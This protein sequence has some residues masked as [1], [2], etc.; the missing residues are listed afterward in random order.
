M[1]PH[2]HTHT[3]FFS[4]SVFSFSLFHHSCMKMCFKAGTPAQHAPNSTPT[5]TPTGTPCRHAHAVEVKKKWKKGNIKTSWKHRKAYFNL[6]KLGM[7]GFAASVAWPQKKTLTP[8]KG[9]RPPAPPPQKKDVLYNFLLIDVC[10]DDADAEPSSSVAI[11][12][13][14]RNRFERS[15]DVVVVVFNV[16]VVSTKKNPERIRLIRRS[17]NET[18]RSH[19]CNRN[20]SSENWLMYSAP[21]FPFARSPRSSPS[22][23]SR[24]WS[25]VFHHGLVKRLSSH[26]EIHIGNRKPRNRPGGGSGSPDIFYRK[27][28]LFVLECT[29]GFFFRWAIKSVPGISSMIIVSVIEDFSS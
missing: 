28:V 3:R 15:A 10:S 19:R 16:V 14:P 29:F 9:K 24:G 25:P 27:K 18:E 12:S 5:G 26:A 11:A 1:P 13:R 22:P 2:T 7:G 6:F 8:K 17:R 21:S 23:P 4:R 20:F